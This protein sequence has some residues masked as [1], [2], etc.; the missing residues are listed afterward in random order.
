M[1]PTDVPACPV[2]RMR[3]WSSRRGAVAPTGSIKT[4]LQNLSKAYGERKIN[5]WDESAIVL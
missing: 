2:R 4:G 3:F 1:R 5:P